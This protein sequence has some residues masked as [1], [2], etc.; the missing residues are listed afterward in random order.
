[1]GPDSMMKPGAQP[2]TGFT[3]DLGRAGQDAIAVSRSGS[4]MP[5]E[6]LDDLRREPHL[7]CF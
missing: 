3:D 1:M 7:W 6:R 2:R 4:R 5:K